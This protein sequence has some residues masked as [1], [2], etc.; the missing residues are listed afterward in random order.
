[1]DWGVGEFCFR[2]SLQLDRRHHPET[3]LLHPFR[4][5]H[6]HPRPP[7]AETTRNRCGNIYGT[8]HS[9]PQPKITRCVTFDHQ[10]PGAKNLD[11]EGTKTKQSRVPPRI[12]LSPN[13]IPSWGERRRVPPTPWCLRGETN[14][15]GT[16]LNHSRFETRTNEVHET[17][18]PSTVE[19]LALCVFRHP[20]AGP[21]QVSGGARGM[22]RP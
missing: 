7:T 1:L 12:S 10:F 8:Y 19:H 21:H 6:F 9:R 13:A 5:R 4:E 14:C 15:R 22:I 17:I 18:R 20:S 16:S 3:N 11:H 2:T